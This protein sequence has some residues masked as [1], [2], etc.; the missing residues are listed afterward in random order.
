MIKHDEK[1]IDVNESSG[2][3]EVELIQ[4][5]MTQ[6]R[7]LDHHE[8]FESRLDKIEEKIVKLYELTYEAE[9][10]RQEGNTSIANELHGRINSIIVSI[11]GAA[12]LFIL[13]IVANIFLNK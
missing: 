7:I 2:I 8:K 6:N 9:L 12:I 1:K 11:A 10:K 5:K 4:I 13:G 3:I